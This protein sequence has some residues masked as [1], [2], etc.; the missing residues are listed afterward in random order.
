[1]I[2]PP[3]YH[4]L[5]MALELIGDAEGAAKCYDEV[6]RQ[7]AQ[8]PGERCDQSLYWTEEALYRSSLLNVRLG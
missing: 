6:I 1:M 2:T 3:V 7:L 5:G 4:P 8:Q